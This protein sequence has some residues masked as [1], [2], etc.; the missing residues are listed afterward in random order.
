MISF[1]VPAHNES[2][3]IQACLQS[4]HRACEGQEYEIIVVADSCSDDTAELAKAV[5]A[6][7]VPVEHRQIAATRHAGVQQAQGEILFFLDADSQTNPLSVAQALGL[8]RQPGVVGGGTV[9]RFDRPIPFYAVLLEPVF[10]AIC[11]FFRLAGGCGLF[12]HRWAYEAVGGFD[13]QFFA[14]EELE[15]CKALKSV[16]RVAIVSSPITTSGRKLR[17]Y[18]VLELFKLVWLYFRSGNNILNSREGLDLWYQRREDPLLP[19]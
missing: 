12:C 7:V 2:A 6:R 10:D 14:G 3:C 13:R 17:S 11:R 8:L 9:F 15:F 4:I 1:V 5:G 16:G 19:S 18:G